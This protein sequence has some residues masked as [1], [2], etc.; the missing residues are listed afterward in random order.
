MAALAGSVPAP[1]SREPVTDAPPVVTGRPVTTARRRIR[2]AGVVGLG[3]VVFMVYV[4]LE[5]GAGQW[6]PSFDRGPL[7]MGAGATGLATFGYW[8]ALTVVRFALA[9]PRRQLPPASVVRWGCAIALVGAALVW[10]RPT[11]VAALI[12][13]VV[14]AGSL[15][16]VFPA[17][18]A[19]TPARVGEDLAHHVIGWQV[20]AAGLG[21][22]VISAIFGVVFQ[23]YGLRNFG[24]ALVTVG[25]LLM[26]GV[27]VLERAPLHHTG[28]PEVG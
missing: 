15:A 13:L 21:G 3:L 8:G 26:V 14:I 27:L 4:G 11:P 28:A 20:G 1:L 7:R 23:R 22:S 24:P 10:W 9:V 19:L 17:L 16:G 12:G 2:V 6:E 5:A 25:A 18:V